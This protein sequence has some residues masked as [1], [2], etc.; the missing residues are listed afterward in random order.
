M[1]ARAVA[2]L[3][4]D[5]LKWSEATEG[6]VAE[7]LRESQQRYRGAERS[8]ASARGFGAYTRRRNEV[9][10]NLATARDGWYFDTASVAA[11]APFAKLLMFQS[12]QG[13][14]KFLNATNLTGN[15]G[16]IPAG[17]TLNLRSI[18]FIIS[19]TTV[20]ADYANI[21]GNC[22]VQFV[23]RNTPIYQ[24][25]PEW[26]PAGCGIMTWAAAQLGTAPTG[27]ATV[28]STSNGLPVQTAAYEFKTPYFMESL[29][30]F[31]ITVNPEVAFNMA[32]NTGVNPLGVG[33]TI[34]VY[35]EGDRK[36]VVT[37]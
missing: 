21:V 9:A 22:S 14:N 4:L 19:N 32:A 30:P 27:T 26:L 36:A 8:R 37:S 24:W 7:M 10:P 20:P 29:L 15:G 17:E 3:R 18:R 11:G 1:S 25:T 2:G 6:Q 12:P 23:V 34:R 33:T 16:Q 35:L 28:T 31:N 13:A 5:S